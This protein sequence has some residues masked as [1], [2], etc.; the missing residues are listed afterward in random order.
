MP[1]D[2]LLFVAIMIATLSIFCRSMI[3]IVVIVPIG[4]GEEIRRKMWNNDR[5]L[6][7]LCRK[8]SK[9]WG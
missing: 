6:V 4:G 9:G 5:P 2:E 7:I 8:L 1:L 3:F